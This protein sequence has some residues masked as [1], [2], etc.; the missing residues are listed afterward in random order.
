MSWP[1]GKPTGLEG[2]VPDAW[3]KRD[4]WLRETDHV[5]VVLHPEP[6]ALGHVILFPKKHSPR[7]QDCD[8]E[9]LSTVGM[10]VPQVK[11]AIRLVT[12][13][14]DFCMIMRC[15]QTAGQKMNHLHFE[16]VPTIHVKPTFRLDWDPHNRR[17]RGEN[18]LLTL[19]AN[20]SLVTMLRRDMGMHHFDGF[21]CVLYETDRLTV[22]FVDQPASTG[23]M[24]IC[25][26][27]VSPDFEDCDPIDFAAC[28]WQIPKL[29]RSLRN[30]L[31]LE[32]FFVIILNGPDAGQSLP[33]LTVQLVPCSR[34]GASV[35]FEPLF[36]LKPPLQTE[37]NMSNALKQILGQEIVCVA[38]NNTAAPRE[39]AWQRPLSREDVNPVGTASPA[40]IRA[41]SPHPSLDG[42]VMSANLIHK[43]DERPISQ[44][45]MASMGSGFGSGFGS[46]PP[47]RLS[48]PGNCGDDRRGP[49]R[50]GGIFQRSAQ[51]SIGMTGMTV[52]RTQDRPPSR[53]SVLSAA[54]SQAS[55]ES[56]RIFRQKTGVLRDLDNLLK[57]SSQAV[58]T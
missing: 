33:H 48:T 4:R 45:S 23:H 51:Q 5:M 12:G 13:Y 29:T 28:L 18:A 11:R 14:R 7:I 32:S 47:S 38:L 16:L 46:G 52:M 57:S 39:S 3:L 37:K 40:L 25:P 42:W 26:K 24:I 15:G 10:M 49:R 6:A 35:S 21:G 58:H 1:L 17:G 44:G 31:N 22:E 2:I 53:L 56:A 36:T 9:T 19:K 55:T 43:K 41:R 54:S 20:G 27:E 50:D 30:T 8:P 34:R